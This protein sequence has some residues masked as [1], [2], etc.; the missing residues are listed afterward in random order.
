MGLLVR[1]RQRPLHDPWRYQSLLLEDERTAD[2]GVAS[3]LTVFLTGRECS[4]Q[5]VMCDLWQATTIADTPPGAIPHQIAQ[6]FDAIGAR[7]SAVRQ[8]KLYNA[9]SFF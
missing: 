3:C 6:A 9:S 7:R 8:V 2:G 4:W 5:C 1:P